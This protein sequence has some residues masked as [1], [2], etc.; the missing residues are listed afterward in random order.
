M[1]SDAGVYGRKYPKAQNRTYQRFKVEGKKLGKF[2]KSRIDREQRVLE[3]LRCPS[4]TIIFHKSRFPD[5]RRSETLAEIIL[6]FP[7]KWILLKSIKVHEFAS[8]L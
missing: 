3:E 1:A 8:S 7:Q 6:S 4:N 2:F 5:A